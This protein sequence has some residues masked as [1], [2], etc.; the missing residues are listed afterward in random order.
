VTEN[1]PV[2]LSDAFS[3]SHTARMISES[4]LLVG[5]SV[6]SSSYDFTQRVVMSSAGAMTPFAQMDREVLVMMRDKL[7]ELGGQPPE[8]PAEAPANPAPPR[9]FNL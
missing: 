8:L 6:A 4:V 7:V 5:N 9:K 2:S 1:K 3:R